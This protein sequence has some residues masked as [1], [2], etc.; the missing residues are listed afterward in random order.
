MNKYLVFYITKSSVTHGAAEEKYD[1]S[2]CENHKEAE[3]KQQQLIAIYADE[4][5]RCYIT[6][7]EESIG[8]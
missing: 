7:I 2:L 1:Y 8:D 6:K 3:E 4:L 5:I